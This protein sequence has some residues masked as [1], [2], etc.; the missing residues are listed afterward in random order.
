D[1]I[2]AFIFRPGFSTATSVTEVS[3]RGVGMDAVRDFLEREG[4]AI[5]LRFT[6]DRAGADYRHFQ[7]VVRLPQQW[8]VKMADATQA[9][10]EEALAG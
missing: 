8:A 5:E 1:V 4:G 10:Q 2:A 6:D 3:G 9:K 7:T